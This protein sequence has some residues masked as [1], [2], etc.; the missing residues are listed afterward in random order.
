M[1]LWPKP[2]RQHIKPNCRNTRYVIYN[3]YIEPNYIETSL[4]I[5]LPAC[6][7]L[8]LMCL[9]I[10]ILQNVKRWI[11]VSDCFFFFSFR[12]QRNTKTY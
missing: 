3:V 8:H 10:Y 11:K 7:S 5:M 4:I 9:Y 1:M 6:G 12:E 2:E